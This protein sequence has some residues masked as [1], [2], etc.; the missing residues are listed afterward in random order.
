MI[1]QLLCI[2]CK[3][4]SKRVFV[5]FRICLYKG[6]RLYLQSLDIYIDGSYIQFGVSSSMP[7]S[8][9]LSIS[10]STSLMGT[11]FFGNLF[12]H[13]VLCTKVC[14][15]CNFLAINYGSQVCDPSISH[16]ILNSSILREGESVNDLSLKSSIDFTTQKWSSLKIRVF[17]S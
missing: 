15:A 5:P 4:K 1:L 17:R 10:S 14:K 8:S 12:L 16:S 6:F 7:N 11:S 9:S 3:T 2:V 13:S